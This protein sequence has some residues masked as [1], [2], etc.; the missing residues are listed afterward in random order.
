MLYLFF[1]IEELETSKITEIYYLFKPI[2]FNSFQASPNMCLDA[3][4]ICDWNVHYAI[5]VVRVYIAV[6]DKSNLDECAN[7]LKK[8][9]GDVLK[10]ST[11]LILRHQRIDI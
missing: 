1:H 7:E 10:A 9:D 3:L 5:K 11:I 2:V 4:E 8:N 6:G